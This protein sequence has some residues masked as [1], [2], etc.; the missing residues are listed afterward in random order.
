M[1]AFLELFSM[2]GRANRAWYFWHIVLDDF[3][4]IGLMFTL[5]MLMEGPLGGIWALPM[6]GTIAGGLWAA[7]AV[8]VKRLHDLERPG[9]HWWLMMVP[10]YNIYLGLVLFFQQGTVGP[11]KYGFDPLSPTRS[12]GLIEDGA[13]RHHGS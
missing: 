9:W 6:L 10:I 13:D 7:I 8:T 3:V 2:K 1:D 12:T 4:I 11:N 5:M